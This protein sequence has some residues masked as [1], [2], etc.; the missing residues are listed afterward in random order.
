[1]YRALS[2]LLRKAKTDGPRGLSSGKRLWEPPGRET[3]IYDTSGI[4]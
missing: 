2:E 3:T 1:M 4:L